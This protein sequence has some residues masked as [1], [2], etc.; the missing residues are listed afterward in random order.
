M[1]LLLTDEEGIDQGVV[2]LLKQKKRQHDDQD[3]DP[4]A[5]LNQGKK[6]KRRRTKDSKSSKKSYASKGNTPPQT[7]K[8]DKPM[9][10]EESVSKPTE[11]VIMDAAND[12][13]GKEVDNGQ[14]QTWFNDMLSDA[15]DPLTFDE[16]IAT[17]IDFYNFTMNRLK[18]DKPTKA[19]LVGPVYELLKDTCQGS[20]KLEYNIE[21]CYKVLSNWIGT[22]L[23]EIVVPLT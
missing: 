18:I 16:L 13:V 7:S 1:E 14:E 8:S 22:T 11:K 15:K 12:N 19:H 17:P 6:T 3:K 2:D 23:K 4:L 5:G 21:E 20:I 10:A 9:H